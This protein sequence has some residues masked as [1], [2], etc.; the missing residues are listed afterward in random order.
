M[1][2]KITSLCQKPG[3]GVQYEYVLTPGFPRKYCDEHSAEAKAKYA[4]APLE[5]P[6]EKPEMSNARA[7]YE[8]FKHEAEQ[9][10]NNTKQMLKDPVGLVVEMMVAGSDIENAIAKVKQAQEA[11]K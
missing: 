3:C 4:A 5:V 2:T 6:V 9:K 8:F 7:K 11:F 1:E 10:T